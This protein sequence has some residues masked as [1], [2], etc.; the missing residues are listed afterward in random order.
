MTLRVA[1]LTVSDGCSA[2]TREDTSG[3]RLSG[4]VEECGHTLVAHAVVPDESDL[5]AQHLVS[6]SDGD[7]I[8]VVLTTGGTG[9]GERDVTPEATRAVLDREI[10]GIPEA[11]RRAGTE[12]TPRAIL[13][14]G[15]AGLRGPT[16]IVNLPGSPSGVADGIAVLEPI[17]VHAVEIARMLPTDHQ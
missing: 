9:L 14:R 1:V 5:I 15:A 17:L 6:W 16:I 2:G 13:S 3:A 10:P 7:G 8:D 11:L 4:W 12:A